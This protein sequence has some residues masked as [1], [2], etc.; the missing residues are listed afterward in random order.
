[1]STEKTPVYDEGKVRTL[2]SLEHIRTRPG[3]YVGRLGNG[4]HPEDGIYVLLKEVIDN[5][6]DEYIMG[7]GRRVDLAVDESGVVRVRDYGRGIPLG[8]LVDCVSKINTG[9]K[10]N[11]D[12]FQFSVGLNGVGLKAV[13]ALSSWFSV[14]S[15]REHKTKI[16]EFANGVLSSEKDLKVDEPNGTEVAFIPAKD[17]FPQFVI[18]DKFIRKRLWNYAY[19][20][21][22]LSLYF[23]GERFY[24]RNGLLDLLEERVT[25][26][27]VYDIIYHKS[28]AL[29]F[30]F[31]HTPGYGETYYSFVNGQYTNDG[32]THQSAFREGIL[33][34]VNEFSGKNYD[35]ADAR[36]GIV[37]AIAIKL[38]DPLFESQTKNKLGN[39]EI[40]GEI[41]NKVREV[42]MA[43]LYKNP[44]VATRLI[45]KIAQNASVRQEI[46]NVKKEAKEKAKKASLKVPN[47]RDC[48]NHLTD[49][50][51]RGAK[52]MVFITE[53]QSAAGSMVSCRD[54]NTQAIYCL[55]GKPLNVHGHRRKTV[56]QNE[57]LYYIMRALDI[58]D[59]L[60]S[61]RYEKV[62]LATDADVDGL[63][64]RN[65]LIT[66]F[67]TFF[68]QLV[69]AEHLFI[70][71][72]PLFRVRN[73]RETVYCY[74]EQERDAA[75]ERLGK[76]SEITRFKGLG[77]ISPNE[78]GQ[79]IGDD[80]RLLQVTVGSLHSV[81]GLLEF[82]MGKNTPE[83]RDYIMENLV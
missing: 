69:M 41:V 1:M 30:A 38:K 31:C 36:D 9:A 65:L 56:Y 43:H 16:A 59:G 80:M 26:E 34:A 55:Q 50:S 24:S 63:H 74:S 83:R 60:E 57:E 78:F 12:V 28:P 70:L 68:E 53:G 72:T 33:K 18:E 47:L 2:S 82:F 71:E 62:I 73:K 49:G 23:A 44:E 20:N 40:R 32:G 37:G 58:E 22:G 77:E 66:F 3:M 35:G 17:F 61:L 19:L 45:E 51:E 42:V 67:L 5:A 48:K 8:K 10:Y 79:F 13:N 81:P 75:S 21:S 15:V 7:Y 64:I 29:E 46:Q 4:S 14:K 76:A 54:V 52:S 6:V 27:K 39:H 11:N 25:E